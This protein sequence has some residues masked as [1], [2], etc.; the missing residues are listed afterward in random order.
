M[1]TKIK[2]T[3]LQIA[4]QMPRGSNAS[5]PEKG[6]SYGKLGYDRSIFS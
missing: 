2:L 5:L 6:R 3:P 1:K 4:K